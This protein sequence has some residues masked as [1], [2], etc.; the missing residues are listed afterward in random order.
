M[1]S[2]GT[3]GR[4]QKGHDFRVYELRME[5]ARLLDFY[6]GAATVEPQEYFAARLRRAPSGVLVQE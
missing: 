4:M 6:G 3:V 2:S 5:T 1:L